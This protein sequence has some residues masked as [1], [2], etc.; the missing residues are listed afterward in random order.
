MSTYS[1]MTGAGLVADY[2]M[3]DYNSACGF[4]AVAPTPG[5]LSSVVISGTET[6]TALPSNIAENKYFDT[7]YPVYITILAA[8][9][10][11]YGGT[12]YFTISGGF[13]WFDSCE[14]LSKTCAD[15]DSSCTTI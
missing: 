3:Y 12:F 5:T 11:E 8:S 14:A 7:N 4:I 2:L 1:G 15:T 6:G 9:D 13:K 10:Y